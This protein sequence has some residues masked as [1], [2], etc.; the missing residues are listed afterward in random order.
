MKGLFLN[1]VLD[2]QPQL[3]TLYF[4]RKQA[5]GKMQSFHLQEGIKLVKNYNKI[6]YADFTSKFCNIVEMYK[7]KETLNCV[8]K[9]ITGKGFDYMIK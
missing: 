7:L 3:H 2:L 6:I 9:L 5:G 4:T 8:N 1:V